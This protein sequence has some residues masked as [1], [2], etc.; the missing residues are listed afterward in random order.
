MSQADQF[1]NAMR[2]QQL[3][4]LAGSP[5]LLEIMSRLRIEAII[6][7]QVPAGAKQQVSH[8]QSARRQR[9]SGR[10]CCARW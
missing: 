8:G 10:M 2:Q 7:K 9:P 6:D 5:L 3:Y 4:N 1:R